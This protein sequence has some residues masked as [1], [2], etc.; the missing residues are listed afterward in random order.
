MFIVNVLDVLR[1]LRFASG[2]TG[3]FAWTL[4]IALF[5]I[6]S[7]VGI[8]SNLVA[9][10]LRAHLFELSRDCMAAVAVNDT[11]TSASIL[12][13]FSDSA[14]AL[15]LS[16]S[17]QP[18][19]EAFMLLVLSV[20]IVVV[21]NTCIANTTREF[22]DARKTKL[23]RSAA[24]LIFPLPRAAFAAFEASVGAFQK[25]DHACLGACSA[26]CTNKFSLMRSWLDF[27]PECR[28]FVAFL[29]S[30]TVWFL[31]LYLLFM[32]EDHADRV[33]RRNDRVRR[34]NTA[35][36]LPFTAAELDSS[37]SSFLLSKAPAADASDLQRCG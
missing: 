5:A 31:F 16:S 32:I 7:V 35:A 27:T 12:L 33:R 9:A 20:L 28:A 3:G 14:A 29:S 26:S 17:I 21:T 25:N 13:Q 18:F 30:P 2:V 23:W 1:M 15:S 37:S 34:R 10:I 6:C 36:Y 22:L 4:S 19:T 8:T 24:V 11:G